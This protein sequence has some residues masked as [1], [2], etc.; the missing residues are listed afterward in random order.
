MACVNEKGQLSSS[1][2]KLLTAIKDTSLSPK[3]IASMA[4]APLF[5]VNSSLRELV[6]VGYVIAD[7][8]RYQLNP[9]Y[10]HLLESNE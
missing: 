4:G 2:V 6:E 10:A 8:G 5:K 1:G 9:E 7:E 3:E